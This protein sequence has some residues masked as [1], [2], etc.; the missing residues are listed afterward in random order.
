M[1]GTNQEL[2]DE[3]DDLVGLE[4]SAKPIRGLAPAQLGRAL[5]FFERM[6]YRQQLAR[7]LETAWCDN[8]APAFGCGIFSSNGSGKWGG[9][10]H[11][12]EVRQCRTQQQSS[13]DSKRTKLWS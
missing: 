13:C 4:S 10:M 1:K 11:S 9:A 2:A 12:L 8:P 5:S 7:T 3:F 6:W